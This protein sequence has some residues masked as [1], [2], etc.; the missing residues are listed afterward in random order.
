ME[1]YLNPG[2]SGFTGI[3]ICACTRQCGFCVGNKIRNDYRRV[4]RAHTF[5]KKH[6][7][8]PTLVIELKWNRSAEGAIAQIKEKHYPD[9]LVGYGGEILLAGISYDREAEGEKRRH[10]C[11]IERIRPAAYPLRANKGDTA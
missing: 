10:T 7:L 9:V 6:S 4:G 1:N 3:G 11:V 8:T 2:N 5:P